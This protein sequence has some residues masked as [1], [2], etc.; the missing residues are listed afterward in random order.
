MHIRSHKNS[1]LNEKSLKFFRTSH[2]E[3][4]SAA[5]LLV[6]YN[7]NLYQFF[8]RKLSDS[9]RISVAIYDEEDDIKHMLRTSYFLNVLSCGMFCALIDVK[10]QFRIENTH[11]HTYLAGVC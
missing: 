1:D 4:S 3:S 11:A 10:S 5:C 7:Q 2:C 6:S 8:P 9:F